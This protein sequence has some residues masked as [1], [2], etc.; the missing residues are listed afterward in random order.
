VSCCEADNISRK[1]GMLL[2]SSRVDVVQEYLLRYVVACA[3]ECN[4][5]VVDSSNVSDSSPI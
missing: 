2:E 3:K 1:A 5:M 4:R